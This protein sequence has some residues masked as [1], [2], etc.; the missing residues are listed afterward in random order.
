MRKNVYGTMPDGTIVE[1]ITLQ[2]E[3]GFSV[4]CITHGATITNMVFDGVDVV[5]GQT[6]LEDYFQCI[7]Y[8]GTT[9]GRYANRIDGGTFELNGITY[10]VGCNETGRGHLHGGERGFDKRVWTITALCDNSVTMELVSPDGDM[11]YPGT[12][13]VAVRFTVEADDALV[14]DYR[15]TTDKDTIL[16]LTNHTYFNLNGYDG[17]D[18]LDTQLQI[19]AD[20]ITP[21]NERMIPTGERMEVTGTPF[22]FRTAKAIGKDIAEPHEQLRIAGGYD[23][24]FCLGDDKQYRHA[25]S[26]YSP[27][28][29][30]QMDCYTDQPGVQ[31][32]T[33]NFLEGDVG[34]GGPLKPHQG[35]CLETQHFAD[36]P[37]HPSFPS[38]VLKTGD[39]FESVTRY[40]FCKR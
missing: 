31:L 1:Q 30:I 33:A 13:A 24:N 10:D 15:A 25:V 18:I 14:I 16:N 37:H 36:S 29:H 8:A 12:L 39:T 23:H 11:G 4:S 35:F 3:N 22:D 17:G 19:F 9:V 27:R 5:L 7:G 20:Y 40:R 38:T 2:N 28:S 32:Y 6:Y 34:K 21:L 26:A